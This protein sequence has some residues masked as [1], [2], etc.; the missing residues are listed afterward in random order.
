MNTTEK[1]RM[2]NDAM[3]LGMVRNGLFHVTAGIAAQGAE[4]LL[5]AR[6]MVAAYDNFTPDNDPYGEHDFG[7]F[8]LDGQKLYFKID[9]Y[10]LDERMHSPDPSDPD[11]TCRVLTVMLASEY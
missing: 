6:L 4:F 1:I 8:E 3:R 5:R 9:Y 10:D 11:V 7:S 2:Q